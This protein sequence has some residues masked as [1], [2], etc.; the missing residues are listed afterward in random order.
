MPVAL[1]SAGMISFQLSF[2]HIAVQ[3]EDKQQEEKAR[4]SPGYCTDRT[5][6]SAIGR[7]QQLFTCFLSG[8]RSDPEKHAGSYNA[9][10]RIDQ[11]FNDL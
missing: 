5:A 1:P 4:H 8:A 11:L 9:Y 10:Y 2:D 3:P 6:C 7:P